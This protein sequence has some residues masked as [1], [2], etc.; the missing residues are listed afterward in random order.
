MSTTCNV[1]AISPEAPKA[2]ADYRRDVAKKAASSVQGAVGDVLLGLELLENDRPPHAV[3]VYFASAEQKLQ[4][5]QAGYR[6]MRAI[7][8]QY[9]TEA[10]VVEWRRSLDFA[11]VYEAGLDHGFIP[12]NEGTWQRIAD[13]CSDEASPVLAPIDAV[14]SDID[15][16]L[17]GAA[18]LRER[19]GRETGSGALSADTVAAA[20]QL[21]A[22]MVDFL[23][24]FRQLVYLNAIL[25]DEP[26][27]SSDGSATKEVAA[28]SR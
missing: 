28:A 26:E 27:A 17:A 19:A 5:A 13:L 2:V 7:L 21:Q 4:T 3:A 23:A 18:L 24:F 10:S 8:A 1:K 6:E 9:P 11:A 12:H 25:P 16:M 22:R 15:S 14:R 20:L